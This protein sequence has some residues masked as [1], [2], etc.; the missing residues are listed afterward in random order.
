MWSLL[1][2]TAI[3]GN[4]GLTCRITNDSFIMVFFI[5]IMLFGA[6]FSKLYAESSMHKSKELIPEEA[7]KKVRP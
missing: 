6:V 7:E 4:D 2:T 5:Q 1:G 3:T